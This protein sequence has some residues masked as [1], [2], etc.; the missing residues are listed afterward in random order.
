MRN[1]KG[2]YID[3]DFNKFDG[4]WKDNLLHGTG[5]IYFYNQDIYEGIYN[6]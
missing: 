2:L 1:G 6:Y 4:E 3:K 5:K